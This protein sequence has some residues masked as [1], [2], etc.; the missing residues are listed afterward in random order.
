MCVVID[1]SVILTHP[2]LDE[3]QWRFVYIIFGIG[4]LIYFVSGCF[5]DMKLHYVEVVPEA[6]K[7]LWRCAFYVFLF[8]SV[9]IAILYFPVFFI[10]RLVLQPK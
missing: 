3:S 8:T 1:V 7:F 4:T 5:E 10:I 6:K 9:S 2:H